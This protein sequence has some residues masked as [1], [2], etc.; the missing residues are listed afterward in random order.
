MSYEDYEAALEDLRADAL[1]WSD[2]AETFSAAK[3]IVAGCR[4]AMYE[5]DGIGHMLGAEANYNEAHTTIQGLADRAP[6]VFTEISD[7]LLDTKRRYE[8][9]DGYSQWLLDQG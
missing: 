7:K 2:L 3:T 8:E 9:A 6:T 4:L 5:M 1:A